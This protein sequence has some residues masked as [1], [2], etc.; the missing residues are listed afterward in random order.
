MTGR[1]GHRLAPT[2]LRVPAGHV[3]ERRAGRGTTVR[4]LAAPE[5]ARAGLSGHRRTA[6]ATGAL[7]RRHRAGLAGVL[8][9]PVRGEAVLV[10]CQ[11]TVAAARA[12]PL[13]D[14]G[15]AVR[16]RARTT[17][18]RRGTHT[19]LSGHHRRNHRRRGPDRLPVT[20]PGPARAGYPG[21]SCC[22]IVALPA[23]AA[24]GHLAGRTGRRAG[25]A[26][27]TPTSDLSRT[28]GTTLSARTGTGTVH[29]GGRAIPAP[30][31]RTR[32]GVGLGS[33]AA[34]AS[35]GP[36]LRLDDTVRTGVPADPGTRAVRRFVPA[37]SALPGD[38]RMTGR[39]ARRA[40]RPTRA[41]AGAVLRPRV[42]PGDRPSRPAPGPGRVGRVRAVTIVRRG[43]RRGGVQGRATGHRPRTTT[44]IAVI[45]RGVRHRTARDRPRTT[46]AVR[47]V[48]PCGGRVRAVRP[49][50]VDPFRGAGVTGRIGPAPAVTSTARP[51]VT[52]R[53]RAGL[54]HAR[55]HRF[56]LV[57]TRGH[58]VAG[59]SR[60]DR[61]DR[62]GLVDRGR[63]G[64]GL[65][66]GGGRGPGIG[67][68]PV[69]CRT[70]RRGRAD[71]GRDRAYAG[72]RASRAWRRGPRDRDLRRVAGARNNRRHG[73][74]RARVARS[75][76]LTRYGGAC[77]APAV[78]RLGRHARPAG[79]RNRRTRATT[80][81]GRHRGRGPLAGRRLTG[82]PPIRHLTRRHLTLWR[83]TGRHLSLRSLTRRHLTRRLT[84]R[85]L[86]LRS[87][88]RRDLARHLTRRHLA[89]RPL[90]GPRSGPSR[91]GRDLPRRATGNPALAGWRRRGGHRAGL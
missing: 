82:R 91:S 1:A 89:P 4:R 9:A 64:S 41:R 69:A 72:G 35:P 23:R 2:R 70:G 44:A 29:P 52:V 46:T 81:S 36:V 5:P 67:T 32:S 50:A 34:T 22:R 49:G 88:T 86:S 11:L 68:E 57:D 10:G 13:D 40:V 7:P 80:A 16:H 20:G 21:R 77:R 37:G 42:C 75:A 55:R 18:H 71:P 90:A 17:G 28:G 27:T 38:G 47:A 60:A 58:G 8:R 83:L 51:L 33:T 12:R 24:A 15:G 61:R 85:H 78:T 66:P 45:R 39:A 74:V 26:R 84:G 6:R 19:L 3:A 59:P 30:G 14:T 73:G 76:R 31:H 63:H 87:L 48:R 43:V 25:A 62:P 53:Q 79:R 65:L 56:G 54:V